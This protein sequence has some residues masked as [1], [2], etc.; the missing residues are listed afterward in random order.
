MTKSIKRLEGY[1]A[2]VGIILLNEEKEVFVGERSGFR[3]GTIQMPQG[4]IDV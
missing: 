2:G 3:N 1:R 4:G